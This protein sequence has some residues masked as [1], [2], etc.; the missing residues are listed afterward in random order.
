MT[1]HSQ[2]YT[3]IGTHTMCVLQARLVK[4]VK[5]RNWSHVKRID[6]LSAGSDRRLCHPAK[7]DQGRYRLGHESVISEPKTRWLNVQSG[8]H[9]WLILQKMTVSGAMRQRQQ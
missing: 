7:D 8:H 3:H 4:T 2:D 9:K 6:M 1:A 5:V